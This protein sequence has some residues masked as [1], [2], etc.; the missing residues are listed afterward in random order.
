MS[1]KL[2]DYSLNRRHL[3]AGAGALAGS[4]LI[5]WRPVAAAAHAATENTLATWLRIQADGT[6]TVYVAVAEMGQGAMTALP[7]MVAEELDV[8]WSAVRAEMPPSGIQFRTM[9]GR[10]V[11]GNSQGVMQFF[12]PMREAGAAARQMLIAAAAGQWQ[13][14]ADECSTAAGRVTHAATGR[15][16]GYGELAAAAAQLPVPEVAALKPA[17]DWRLIGQPLPRTDIPAKVDGSAVYG[18]DVTLEGMQTASIMACPAFG[19]RLKSVDPK[20]ALAMPGVRKVVPLD[21]AVAVVADHYWAAS[22]GLKALQPEWDLNDASRENSADIEAEQSALPMSAGVPGKVTGEVEQAFAAAARVVEAQYQ[23]P[24]LAHMCMEPMNATAHVEAGRVRIWA[25]TQVETDTAVDVAKALN[26]SP[27]TVTVY[28]TM[29]GGGFGR[30]SYTDFAVQAALIAGATGRPL[31]LIWSREEDIRQDH[32]RPAMGARYR[33]ALDAEGKL[34]ALDANVVGPSLIDNFKLPPNLD[35]VINTM[36]LSGDAYLIPNQKLT[37]ARRDVGIPVGIWRSTLLS[38]NGFFAESFVDELAAAAKRDPLAFRRELTQGNA[39]A[40]KTLDTLA[41]IFDF[42][43]RADER[44]GWGLA[45][46]AGWNC[47]C[48]A[49]MDVSLLP[50]NSIRIH[51][52]ACAFDAGTVINPAVATSQVQGGFLYGLCAALWGDIRIENGQVLPGNFDTQP[53]LRMNQAPSIR[54]QLVPSDAAPG[55]VGE[56]PTSAAAP[57][58]INAIVAAGGERQRSLPLARSGYRLST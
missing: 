10:R 16:A 31:Q 5:G 44:R 52:V 19:G 30:R 33:G 43:S 27:D 3:L 25:P 28:S 41:Q 55:G 34:L 45:I 50:D 20:P 15:S 57:A 29:I 14:P 9:R 12:K 26:V 8:D 7:A 58:L 46:T 24:F 53:V 42:S 51:D 49:A 56:L 17:A 23:V 36:A 2:N 11:T 1:M 21:N 6:V 40:E 18:I 22:Q 48:A 37:Y 38:E 39:Q 54:V 13:V 4:L 35:T 32:Y 47:V